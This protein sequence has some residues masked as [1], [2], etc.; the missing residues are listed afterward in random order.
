MFSDYDA[1]DDADDLCS[2]GKDDSSPKQQGNSGQSPYIVKK[3]PKMI[4]KR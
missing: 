3:V 1:E 2:Y 4:N